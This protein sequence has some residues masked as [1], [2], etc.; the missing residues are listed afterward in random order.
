MDGVRAVLSHAPAEVLAERTGKVEAGVRAASPS[1]LSHARWS[2]GIETAV[3]KGAR[4]VRPRTVVVQ[5][6]RTGASVKGL[7]KEAVRQK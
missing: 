4:R 1:S 6:T 5:A 2:K 7:A 3:V